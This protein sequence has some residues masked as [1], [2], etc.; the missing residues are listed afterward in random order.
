MKYKNWF[1]H[2]IGLEEML[3]FVQDFR[4]FMMCS[5]ENNTEKQEQRHEALYS[6]F[7]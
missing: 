3:Y 7:Q 1:I 5:T 6:C 2:P 4:L